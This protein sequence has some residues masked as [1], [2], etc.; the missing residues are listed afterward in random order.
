MQVIDCYGA[1][2]FSNVVS[3][4]LPTPLPQHNQQISW[5]LLEFVP[6]DMS[7]RDHTETR[8][9]YTT[10]ELVLSMEGCERRLNLAYIDLIRP[11]LVSIDLELASI[12]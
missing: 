9:Q 8:G 1:T 12:D 10:A 4:L 5:P 2:E 3:Q 6:A 11:K 7:T